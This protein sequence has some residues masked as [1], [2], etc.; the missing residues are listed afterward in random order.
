MSTFTVSSNKIIVT[1]P[2]YDIGTWCTATLE[3]VRNGTYHAE[4]NSE[5]KGVWGDRIADITIYHSSV[6]GKKKRLKFHWRDSNIGVD[7]GQAGFFDFSVYEQI[8]DNQQLDKS[9]YDEVSEKTLSSNQWG[10]VDSKVFDKTNFG[11]ASSSG[12]G[13]GVYSLF[14]AED[15]GEI[16]AARIVFISEENDDYEEI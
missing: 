8:K 2:C 4:V 16:I 7:S 3:H 6:L 13:D 1:D 5:N 10:V 14:V 12:Y 11:V 15:N 9:F